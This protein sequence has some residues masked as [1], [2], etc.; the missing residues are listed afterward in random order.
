MKE[1]SYREFSDETARTLASVQGHDR[2]PV[3]G[4]IELTRLCSLKCTHCYI[5]DA[6]WT[7]D[8]NEISTQHLKDLLDVL[9]A[10]GTMWLCFT[11]GEAMIRKDFRELWVYAKNKGFIMTLFTNATLLSESMAEFLVKHPPFNIE[12]S[13]YGATEETYEKVTLVKGSYKRFMRGIENLRKSGLSWKMKTVL[14]NENAHEL[15]AMTAMAREW[16][17]QFKFDGKI[18]PSVGEG[19][20]GGMAPCA[21]RITP[22]ELIETEVKTEAKKLDDERIHKNYSSYVGRGELLFDC[23]AGKNSFYVKS[24]GLL[25]MCLMTQHHGRSLT[26]KGTIENGFRSA[27]DEFEEI[28]KIKR[29]PQSPC[30]TCDIAHLCENC[31]GFS[32]LENGNEH[33]AVEFLCRS[34]H[35]KALALKV[36][37]KC[38]IRHFVY[39]TKKAGEKAENKDEK[40][41]D[42]IEKGSIPQATGHES[43]VG[44]GSST[45]G[46]V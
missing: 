34:A 36:P 13:I 10:R 17:V 31:P 27:W 44:C 9:A 12:V 29:D 3:D 37:H 25:Q 11:G 7:K 24:D 20:T 38:D 30:R 8:P 18:N 42:E 6:R 5:G 46:C 39:Q 33:G 15:D 28:R 22:E 16:G 40:K 1:R 21:S 26:D 23:G 14:I 35:L 2:I 32:H 41:G 43:S 45:C 4:M 19:E